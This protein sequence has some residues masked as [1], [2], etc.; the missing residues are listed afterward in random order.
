MPMLIIGEGKQ[1]EKPSKPRPFRGIG[2]SYSESED[3]EAPTDGEDTGSAKS[4]A[5]RRLLKGLD[6]GNSS[7]VEESLT[8][9]VQAC[10]NEEGD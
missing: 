2:G 10:M 9:F 8:A 3:S 6:A 1:E 7:L 4:S 5:V